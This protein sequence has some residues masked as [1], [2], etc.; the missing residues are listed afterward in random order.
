MDVHPVR[1]V[2]HVVSAP[3]TPRSVPRLPWSSS[4]FVP[5]KCQALT[6]PFGTRCRP[7]PAE[8]KAH[9]LPRCLTASLSRSLPHRRAASPPRC[10]A[11]SS[12]RPSVRPSLP[13][14][15]SLSPS[16]PPP[17][18]VPSLPPFIPPSVP[19]S[20][21]RS[22]A[23]SLPPS[24]LPPSFLPPSLRPPLWFIN[25]QHHRAAA[26]AL[27]LMTLGLRARRGRWA[28]IGVRAAL[29]HRS[30]R[31]ASRRA[32]AGGSGQQH[33]VAT[34]RPPSPCKLGARCIERAGPL[35]G[36][37]DRGERGARRR[38]P[39]WEAR[40]FSRARSGNQAGASSEHEGARGWSRGSAAAVRLGGCGPPAR[41]SNADCRVLAGPATSM[42]SCWAR[43]RR[44]ARRRATPR[45]STPARGRF[46]AIN[47]PPLK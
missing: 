3:H 18:L 27:A 10:V 33:T 24:L 17:S 6:D 21:T 14:S 12:V 47:K 40:R 30:Q 26:L 22:L 39:R 13:L 41:T 44:R 43:Q 5:W 42:A 7:E 29:T 8:G 2:R 19:P 31:G 32:H 34:A 28:V 46:L 35:L 37:E 15:P 9:S 1:R 25:G 11:A 38:R 4:L 16:L 20:L 23:C 45:R 36:A